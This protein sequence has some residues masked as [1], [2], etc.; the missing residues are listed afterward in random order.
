MT[1]NSF[2]GRD[3]WFDWP[4]KVASKEAQRANSANH[5][6]PEKSWLSMKDS[7]SAII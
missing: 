1:I 3:G 4:W 5:V 6:Y 2:L 7:S